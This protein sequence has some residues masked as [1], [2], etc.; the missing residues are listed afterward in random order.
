MTTTIPTPPIHDDERLVI[1]GPQ[2]FRV[3]GEAYADPAVFD[4]EIKRIFE[5]TWIFVG[6]ES[7]IPQPGD[8]KTSYI[9]TQP[10]IVVRDDGGA[11]RI[12]VNRCVHRGAVV[13]RELRGRTTTFNCPYH[14]WTYKNDGTLIGIPMQHEDGGYSPSFDAPAGLYRVPRVETYRGLIFGTFDEHATSLDEHLGR[15]KTF[16]DRKFNRSPAGDVVLASEPYV[17]VFKGNWKFQSENIIDGY[18]FMFVHQGFVKLQEKYGDTTGD[19]GVHKGGNK[20]EMRKVRSGG[21]TIGCP[22]GHG[23]AEIPAPDLEP[24]LSGEYAAYYRGLLEQHGA[25]ELSWI[26]GGGSSMMFPNLGIIHHQIRTWRPIGP[27]LTEVTVYPFELKDAPR[28]FNDGW[29]RSQERF[30]GPAGYGMS[31]DVEV[32]ALNQQGLAGTAVPWII[33]ERGIDT[34]TR[35]EDGLVYGKPMGET[36]LRAF[37]RRWAA[38]MER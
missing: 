15:A 3:R 29:L 1:E 5:K 38:L 12:L 27:A 36:Q 37:W 13:C 21:L 9:G 26:L 35:D 24:Y 31:D 14:S 2:T 22:Q 33:L 6:H 10:V 8:Y 32:F 7:E 25:E 28:S 19:F 20:N 16:I 23:L 34:D 17:V 18:H 30:Y 11:I 4:R